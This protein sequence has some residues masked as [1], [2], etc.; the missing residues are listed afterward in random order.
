MSIFKYGKRSLFYVTILLSVITSVSGIFTAYVTGQFINIATHGTFES[1]VKNIILAAL[2]TTIFFILK[3]LFVISKNSLI[4]SCNLNV[5]KKAFGNLLQSTDDHSSSSDISFLTNDLK[6]LETKGFVNEIAILQNIFIFIF[7]ISYGFYLDVWTTVAFFIA[8]CTPVIVSRFFS[9]KIKKSSQ[10]WSSYNGSYVSKLNDYIKGRDTIINYNAENEVKKGFINQ[11][12]LLEGS[13]RSMNNTVNS[14]NEVTGL[15]ANLFLLSLSFGFGIYQVLNHHLLLG[16][17][18]AIVQVSNYLINPL[19]VI[20]NANNERKTTENILTKIEQQSATTQN[21]H[22]VNI[23]KIEIINAGIIVNNKKLFSSL[24][25]T[26]LK[27]EKVLIMAPSGFG[28]STLL[29]A[30]GGFI[31]FS[32]GKYLINGQ[33]SN[34]QKLKTSVSF[35]K[36]D[37]F[38]F[39][40]TI[41]FNITMGNT[42]TSEEIEKAIQESALSNIVKEKGL[43]YY[44]GENGKNLSG[45]QLQ[46]IEIARGLLANRGVILADEISS[47]LDNETSEIIY[48]NMFNSEV[49]LIDVSHKVT[50]NQFKKY[51]Q[52]Y[53]LDELLA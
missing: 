40:D 19:L 26:V 13:L 33:Q 43:D 36:Q 35:I 24:N 8:S 32:E 34:P 11:S 17:F 31:N 14:T 9:N 44:V 30:I 37:P 29:K 51:T 2:G 45:G 15:V 16:S 28:K 3:M 10:E 18:I 41:L 6:L 21:N 50:E 52:I 22:S 7:A 48:N 38:I 27:G 23:E 49:T 25:M 1:L 4:L 39:D 20:V 5:K 47:A 46:R 53:H 42:Y 12:Q